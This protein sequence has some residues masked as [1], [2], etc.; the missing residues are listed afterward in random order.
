MTVTNDRIKE[1]KDGR[2][3]MLRTEY[4]QIVDDCVALFASQVRADFVQHVV[5]V[6]VRGEILKCDHRNLHEPDDHWRGRLY[7]SQ[8]DREA[9]SVGF[10][11]AFR[12]H[13]LHL[14][15]IPELND[16][17]RATVT[18]LSA[19]LNSQGR[20]DLALAVGTDTDFIP[21]LAT[22]MGEEEFDERLRERRGAS[23]E[24]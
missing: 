15:L 3:V 8:G 5:L 16:A 14:P 1:L 22:A 18:A 11:H 17:S 24:P 7:M 23:R 2:V 19:N 21:R 9:T 6:Q 20:C 4:G 12:E 10:H 13:V